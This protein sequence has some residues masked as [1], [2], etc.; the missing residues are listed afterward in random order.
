M[1]ELEIAEAMTRLTKNSSNNGWY[2]PQHLLFNIYTNTN[3]TVQIT[4]L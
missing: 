1:Y 2:D 4:L 3:S